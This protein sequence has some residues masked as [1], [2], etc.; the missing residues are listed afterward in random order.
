MLDEEVPVTEQGPCFQAGCQQLAAPP[1]EAFPAAPRYPDLAQPYIAPGFQ[2]PGA[3]QEVPCQYNPGVLTRVVLP[4][5][6]TG[7]GLRMSVVVRTV[8]ARDAALHPSTWDVP[9]PR[10]QRM[11]QPPCPQCWGRAL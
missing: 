4:S 11:T 3:Q 6:D 5:G 8:G 9:H 1:E 7:P 2:A 10:P